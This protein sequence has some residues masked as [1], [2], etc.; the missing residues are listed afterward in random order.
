GN[1]KVKL[2]VA[3]LGNR[4][5]TPDALGP[6]AVDNLEID[7]SL[8]AIAP[9]VFGQTGMETASV[10][11]GV[12]S[13]N[14]PDVL[15]VVD[16]LAARS[17][18]RLNQ[19]IQL[20]NTG[21]QPGS[22]VGNNREEINKENM[23]VPVIAIGV[24][25]VVDAATIVND[26]LTDLLEAL[27]LSYLIS[28]INEREKYYFVKEVMQE[29]LVDMYVTPKEVDETI[30]RIAYTISEAINLVQSGIKEEV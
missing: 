23:K 30:R 14:K 12:I 20:S 19:T 18:K 10:I 25:T 5:V 16:A 29:E 3:G 13:E 8:S 26:T 22:G 28:D 4:N 27:S 2:L 21:I 15:I 17:S 9:G 6:L 24:P 1:G 11:K 7:S